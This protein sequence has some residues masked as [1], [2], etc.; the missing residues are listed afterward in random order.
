VVGGVRGA[1][2]GTAVRGAAVGPNGQV[3]AGRGA[4][5]PGGYGA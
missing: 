5:G 2:G 4:I 1:A 3:V